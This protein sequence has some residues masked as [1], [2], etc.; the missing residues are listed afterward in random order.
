M[1]L[2]LSQ[3]LRISFHGRLLIDDSTFGI[4]PR[5]T[6]TGILGVVGWVGTTEAREHPINAHHSA[7]VVAAGPGTAAA[8]ERQWQ[9]PSL[10]MMHDSAHGVASVGQEERMG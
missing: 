7:A 9:H 5:L 4:C 2:W 8:P 3:N 6:D 1:S 10:L